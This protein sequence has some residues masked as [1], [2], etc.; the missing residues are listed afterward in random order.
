M[1]EKPFENLAVL[2]EFMLASFDFEKL[3]FHFQEK[4]Q[5]SG[6]KKKKKKSLKMAK[7]Q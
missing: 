3:L 2:T 7:K 1:K 4:F 6:S 5:V